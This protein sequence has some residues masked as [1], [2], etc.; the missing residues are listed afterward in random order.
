MAAL[1]YMAKLKRGLG[2][3]FGPYSLHDFLMNM[4]LI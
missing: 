3:A 4:F 2:I 1:G